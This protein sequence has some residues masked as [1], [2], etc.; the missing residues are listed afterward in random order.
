MKSFFYNMFGWEDYQM[1]LYKWILG[2]LIFFG[3]CLPFLIKFMIWV[4]F[5]GN[6]ASMVGAFV[7]LILLLVMIGLAGQ[8]SDSA[9][10]IIFN[11]EEKKKIKNDY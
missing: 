9:G 7:F 1:E 6:D 11:R 3:V 2:A 10:E 5:D 4:D 8:V